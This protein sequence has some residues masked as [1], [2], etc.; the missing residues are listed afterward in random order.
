MKRAEEFPGSTDPAR[1][2]RN[3]VR[4]IR[5]R[6]A[7]LSA[8]GRT[9]LRF[10][11]FELQGALSYKALS[12]MKSKHSWQS[13]KDGGGRVSPSR[14]TLRT[15]SRG[16]PPSTAPRTS[17]GSRKRRWRRKPGSIASTSR[18]SRGGRRSLRWRPLRSWR[19]RCA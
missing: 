1:S 19:K 10:G 17:K 4:W 5:R 18:R 14:S 8:M 7:E 13:F 15:A 12:M 9:S 2:S 3:V 16:P 6:L 11:Y